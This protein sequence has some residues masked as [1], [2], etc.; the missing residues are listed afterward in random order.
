M[1]RA[2]DPILR[3]AGPR[4]GGA[5]CAALGIA[6]GATGGGGARPLDRR[7]LRLPQHERFDSLHWRDG[8]PV[9]AAVIA[10]R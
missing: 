6:Y 5:H 10:W 4:P 2:A 1:P 7:R 8:Q 9:P 3:P